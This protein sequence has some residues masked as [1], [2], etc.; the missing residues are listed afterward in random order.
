[1]TDTAPQT[2]LVL[3]GNEAIGRGLVEA[4]C[5]FVASYPGTPSS[6]IL[7][8][9]VRFKTEERLPIF[10]HWAVNEKVA[11]DE[12][13]AAAYAGKRAAVPMKQVGLNVAADSLM[14]AAYTGVKGGLVIICAD[15]PGPHSSQTEQDSRIFAMFAKIPVL[16][17]ADAREAKELV[18]T[19]FALSERHEIPVMLRPSI[20][21]CHARTE[22]P[23]AKVHWLERRAQFQRDPSRWAATPRHRYALHVKLNAKL[24]AIRAELA[25]DASLNFRVALPGAGRGIPRQGIIAAGVSYAVLRDLLAELGWED[26][27]S[28]LKIGSPHPLPLALVDP[29]C[30]EHDEVLLLEDPGPAIE[31][32]IG[33][34]RRV[35]G[36]LDGSVPAAGELTPEVLLPLVARFAGEPVNAASVTQGASVATEAHGRAASQAAGIER[37]ARG[38][39]WSDTVQRAVAD[40][41]LPGRPPTLCPGCGHRAAFYAIKKALPRAI[42]TSDIGCYT[43]GINLK[44]VDTVLDM[45]AGLTLAAG[46]SHAYAQDG[47][48]PPIVATM[49]DSTFFH[50]GIPALL[51]AVASRARFVFVLL[52]N[53]ITAMTGMQTTP[54]LGIDADGTRGQAVD[55]LGV[56]RGCGVGFLRTVDP[57]RTA[58]LIAL[59]KEAHAYTRAADGGVAVIVTQRPCL[60]AYRDR[61]PTRAGALVVDRTKC[62]LCL[63]CIKRFGCPALVHDAAHAAITVDAALCCGCGVCIEAC[64]RDALRWDGAEAGDR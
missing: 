27:F 7:P 20:R 15:D 8:A 5:H 47:E 22:V 13:L 11:F 28:L 40:L 4:S 18:A 38:V 23:L 62:D 36:R 34:R 19:A 46:F 37:A 3:L 63:F 10:T 41:A 45:G 26:R 48:V 55:L 24:E 32:Q 14:S 57:Y 43:L 44:A 9:V 2:S 16:D 17:P 35:R 6:E 30:A 42:F 61:R 51:D 21:V 29:F 33:D 50:S 49:G 1:M 25:A 12:A 64:P 58:E 31:L 39:A 56:I 59:V 53:A 54:A 52:D 60:I